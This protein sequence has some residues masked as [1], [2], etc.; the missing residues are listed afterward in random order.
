M[1]NLQ[2]LIKNGIM[3]DEDLRDLESEIEVKKKKRILD[4]WEQ[5]LAGIQRILVYVYVCLCQ[6]QKEND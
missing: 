6:W 2:E 4:N 3:T 5:Y 1:I